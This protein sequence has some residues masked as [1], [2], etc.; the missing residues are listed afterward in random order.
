MGI[1]QI[2]LAKIKALLPAFQFNWSQM[3]SSY[4]KSNDSLVAREK[5]RKN[6]MV[7]I[8]VRSKKKIQTR[9]P[10]TKRR[11]CGTRRFPKYPV[12]EHP[13]EPTLKN[14]GWGTQIH[15]SVFASGPPAT[16]RVILICE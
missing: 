15:S 11:T 8:D 14:R 10:G 5:I 12:Q 1:E 3:E 2:Q 13:K 16:L 7:R 6:W 9:D 4:A